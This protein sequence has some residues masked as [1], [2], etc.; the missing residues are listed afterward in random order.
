MQ[1]V[2]AADALQEV[3][4]SES[5]LRARVTEL[6]E[7]I[8]RGYE[9]IDG[10][11]LVVGMLKGSF[12]FLADLVR[13]IDLHCE[14]DFM[15]ASSYGNFTES[16]GQ[17]RV[18]RDLTGIE[19]QHVLLVEDI[20]DSGYTMDYILRLLRSRNPASLKLA[21]LLDK[22]SRRRVPVYIDYRGFE[23]ED[24]FVVGYG[25]DFAGMYRNLPFIG[26]LK[27]ECYR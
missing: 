18:T 21:S 5:E 2:S 7:E 9:G 16:S 27:P 24:K 8:R 3:L 10:R 25:L 13:A 19:G 11:L 4:I 22:P 23:I 26:V 14:I 17:I 20:V 1:M 6:G 12:I 15:A